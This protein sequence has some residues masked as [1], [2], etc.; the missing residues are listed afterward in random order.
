LLNPANEKE[1]KVVSAG[2][3]VVI[4]NASMVGCETYDEV[5]QLFQ[6]GKKIRVIGAHAMNKTSSRS[7][8]VFTIYYEAVGKGKKVKSKFNIV[9]LAGS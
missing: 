8:A 4:Q 3:T 9:D 6:D 1:I 5:L 2:D 7:H